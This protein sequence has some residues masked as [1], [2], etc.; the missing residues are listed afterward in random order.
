[1]TDERSKRRSVISSVFITYSEKAFRGRRI[2]DCTQLYIEAYSDEVGLPFNTFHGNLLS[3]DIVDHRS[4]IHNLSSCEIKPEKISGLNE[5]R[6][7]D[8]CDTDAVLNQ[9]SFQANW[10]LLQLCT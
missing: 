10:E 2:T 3:K 5:I 6:T 7:N 4:Y 8:F 9:L 1:M